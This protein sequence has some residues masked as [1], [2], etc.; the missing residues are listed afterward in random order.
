MKIKWTPTA[1]G[2]LKALEDYIAQDNPAAAYRVAQTIRK[3]VEMLVQHPYS[4]RKGR[5][6]GT[7][8]LVISRTPYIVAYAVSGDNIAIPA[9]LHH[10]RKCPDVF[11]ELT[12]P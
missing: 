9:V 1:A 7:R 10:S 4:G 12:E 5:V 2:H 8:E 3:Q 6:E 11:N